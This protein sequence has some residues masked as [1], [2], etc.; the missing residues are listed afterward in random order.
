MKK[1]SVYP[2]KYLKA[3]DLRDKDVT[4][5]IESAEYI[6]LQGKPS[7]LV[8][9]I[10]KDK[11]L[12]VKPSVW[13]QIAQVVGDDDSDNWTGHKITLF[14]TETDF[15]G[16]TYEV[17]RVRTKKRPMNGSRPAPKIADPTSEPS[18]NIPHE[19]DF[20]DDVPF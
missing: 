12:I 1:D 11:G 5:E 9:F 15:A 8:K 6:T 17:V 16:Q 10:G 20:D 7:L 13:D 14:P 2:S 19:P 3:T 18:D 4:V